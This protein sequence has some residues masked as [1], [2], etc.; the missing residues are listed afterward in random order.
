M[1]TFSQLLQPLLGISMA[2]CGAKTYCNIFR[3]VISKK[4]CDSKRNLSKI[5]VA[6]LERS[7]DISFI[8][9]E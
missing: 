1:N 6:Q 7:G 9:T 5:Q 2:G 4:I 8:K 3:S